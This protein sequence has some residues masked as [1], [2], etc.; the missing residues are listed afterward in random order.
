MGTG[1]NKKK[2]FLYIFLNFYFPSKSLLD[3][4]HEEHRQQKIQT[5]NNK[6]AELE[7]QK[8]NIE[9]RKQSS[10]AAVNNRKEIDRKK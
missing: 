4:F 1:K 10:E 2:L 3:V 7:E 8:A 9:Q 6:I 5:I